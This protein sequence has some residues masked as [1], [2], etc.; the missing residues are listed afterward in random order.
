[1]PSSARARLH[2]CDERASREA[3]RRATRRGPIVRG[4][5]L[6]D[7]AHVALV[8]VRAGIPPEHTTIT[9]ECHQTTTDNS[10]EQGGLWDSWDSRILRVN[11]SSEKRN[12]LEEEARQ[13]K[14]LGSKL[15]FKLAFLLP[16]NA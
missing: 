10:A 12:K 2:I 8:G 6:V 15:A 1:M 14:K 7:R 4:S 11:A 16:S 9:N 3:A 5:W 13:Q